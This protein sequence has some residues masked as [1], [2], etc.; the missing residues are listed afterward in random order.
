[1]VLTDRMMVHDDRT[2]EH[3][4]L[5]SAMPLP[6]QMPATIATETPW[7]PKRAE[8]Y[9]RALALPFRSPGVI[10]VDSRRAPEAFGR[11]TASGNC[12]CTCSKAGPSPGS[13]G[14]ADRFAG[15]GS[16]HL[17]PWHGRPQLG[18][19]E[20]SAARSSRTGRGG[21]S[22][23]DEVY[24]IRGAGAFISGAAFR[25]LQAR[26]GSP[27]RVPGSGSILASLIKNSSPPLE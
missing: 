7:R 5:R 1:M 23:N 2:P 19:V 11:L 13:V 27:R 16:D 9:P 8:C 18:H 20:A 4:G 17:A 6:G 22:C 12:R 21:R 15:S 26:S 14:T 25:A 10:S 24:Q 3:Q